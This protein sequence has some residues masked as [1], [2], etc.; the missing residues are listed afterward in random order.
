MMIM[1]MPNLWIDARN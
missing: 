1:F